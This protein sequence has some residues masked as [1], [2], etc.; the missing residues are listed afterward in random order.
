LLGVK[1]H[2]ELSV[3]YFECVVEMREVAGA[4][5]EDLLLGCGEPG[6][7]RRKVSASGCEVARKSSEE[8]RKDDASE[9]EVVLAACGEPSVGE[10][11][12]PDAELGVARGLG[13][14]GEACT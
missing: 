1:L 6:Q 7:E 9:L 11:F 3:R 13:C 4:Q 5:V 14:V 12:L 8:F 10:V 2:A